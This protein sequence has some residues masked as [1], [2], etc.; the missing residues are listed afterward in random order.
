MGYNEKEVSLLLTVYMYEEDECANDVIPPGLP[1]ILNVE[2]AFY[3]ADF[4]AD[5]TASRIVEYVDDG[6]L[7]DRRAFRERFGVTLYTDFLSTGS[8]AGLLVHGTN[9]IV[10]LRNCPKIISRP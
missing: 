3:Q 6:V 7:L 4:T 5:S 8:K 1:K 2:A 10:N 9:K